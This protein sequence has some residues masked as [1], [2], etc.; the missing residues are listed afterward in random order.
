MLR[1]AKCDVAGGG[2][3]QYLFATI[4]DESHE[5]LAEQKSQEE[6]DYQET[7]ASAMLSRRYPYVN[8]EVQDCPRQCDME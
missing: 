7:L 5:S 1:D 2:I 4:M 3:P 8:D 6:V